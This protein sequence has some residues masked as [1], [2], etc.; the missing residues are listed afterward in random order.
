MPR[1]RIATQFDR[2]SNTEICIFSVKCPAPA[3]YE[4]SGKGAP[5]LARCAT[6]ESYHCS[7]RTW[8]CADVSGTAR[9]MTL[10]QIRRRSSGLAPT[11]NA[12]GT[13]GGPKH[14]SRPRNRRVSND[15]SSRCGRTHR[16]RQCTR[17]PARDPLRRFTLHRL[18]WEPTLTFSVFLAAS[19][20]DNRQTG[21]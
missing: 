19:G 13:N 11:C 15:V 7:E 2:C 3:H 6:P 8:C 1:G 18:P 16:R 17:S 10:T 12:G 14:G 20:S 21:A 5:S 9:L 4:P